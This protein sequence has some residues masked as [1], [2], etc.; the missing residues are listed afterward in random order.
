MIKYVFIKNNLIKENIDRALEYFRGKDNNNLYFLKSGDNLIMEFQPNFMLVFYKDMDDNQQRQFLRLFGFL[1]KN[2]FKSPIYTHCSLF[3]QKNKF[4][5]FLSDF[6]KTMLKIHK[7]DKIKEIKQ[8]YFRMKVVTTI[9]ETHEAYYS[10]LT[11]LLKDSGNFLNKD[12]IKESFRGFL[13]VDF[14]R[15]SN[16]DPILNRLKYLVFALP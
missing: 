3:V 6:I 5:D 13:G 9:L 11:P 10:V 12:S 7:S 16:K 4:V 15:A 2:I 1:L 8:V 14:I